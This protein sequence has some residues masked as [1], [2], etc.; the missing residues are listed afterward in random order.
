MQCYLKN[1]QNVLK[2]TSVFNLAKHSRT[3]C[4]C[5][6]EKKFSE[7][8]IRFNGVHV[9]IEKEYASED[10]FELDLIELLLK[11]RTTDQRRSAFLEV[12]IGQS[13]LIPVA[14]RHGFSYHHAREDKA[15]LSIWLDSE[16]QSKLPQFANHSLAAAG[17]CFNEETKDVLLVKDKGSFSKW[18]KFP[19]G[20]ADIGEDIGDAAVRETFEETGIKS[21]FQSVLGFGEMHGTVFN[22]SGFYYICRLQP[23]TLEINKCPDEIEACEW[24][25]IDDVLAMP[26]TTPFVRLMCQLVVQGM[27]NSFSDVD[28]S[29]QQTTSWL[30]PE[31]KYNFY[32]RPIIN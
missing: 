29:C 19:G 17:C 26:E 2:G 6:Q 20:V 18:W 12:P 32:Y 3:F 27:N 14:A 7:K 21:Q 9:K 30:F 25:N 8:Q 5:G 24:M 13:N 28:V 22:Q 23:L 16:T 4:H 11:W 31:K 10:N 15:V 1:I